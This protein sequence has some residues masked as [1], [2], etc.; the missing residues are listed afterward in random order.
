M[1]VPLVFV[2]FIGVSFCLSWL[3]CLVRDLSGLCS[4]FVLCACLCLYVMLFCL[5]VFV[6][7]DWFCVCLLCVAVLCAV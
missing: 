3:A 6:F 7:L 4:L 2:S 5:A 1:C